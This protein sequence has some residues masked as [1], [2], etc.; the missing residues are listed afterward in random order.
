MDTGDDVEL[1][2][3]VHGVGTYTVLALVGIYWRSRLWE[4]A[5]VRKSHTPSRITPPSDKGNATHPPCPLPAQ[6]SP[7]IQH[8][9]A[10]THPWALGKKKS[11]ESHQRLS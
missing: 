3:V 1:G 8:S 11:G 6:N 9:G 4:E 7:G 10:H 5:E 2:A